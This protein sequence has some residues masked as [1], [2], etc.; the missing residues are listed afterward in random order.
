[1]VC[2]ICHVNCVADLCVGCI[3]SSKQYV[4]A[5]SIRDDINSIDRRCEH[6]AAQPV[7]THVFAG[8][9]MPCAGSFAKCGWCQDEAFAFKV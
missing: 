9:V 4:V 1:M 5:S 7:K 3:A 6:F 8:R 2:K